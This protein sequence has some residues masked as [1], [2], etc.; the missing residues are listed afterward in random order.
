M[1]GNPGPGYDPSF[2]PSLPQQQAR[3]GSDWSPSQYWVQPPQIIPPP[4]PFEAWVPPPEQ[5]VF[6]ELPP[7]QTAQYTSRVNFLTTQVL[8]APPPVVGVNPPQQNSRPD[9]TLK[10]YQPTRDL[11]SAFATP[12]PPPPNNQLS[13]QHNARPDW[14]LR[15]YS[16]FQPMGAWFEGRTVA[17]IIPPPDFLV[18]GELPPDQTALLLSI[19]TNFS[20]G[21]VV[22]VPPP[23]KHVPDPQQNWRPY[24]DTAQQLAIVKVPQGVLAGIPVVPVG[25][26]FPGFTY[27]PPDM[28]ALR[29][30]LTAFSPP[31]AAGAQIPPTAPTYVEPPPWT[32]RDYQA[33]QDQFSALATPPTNTY[34]PGLRP[35]FPVEALIRDVL[36]PTTLQTVQNFIL[37]PPPPRVIPPA[38]PFVPWKDWTLREYQAYQDVFSA[39]AQGAPVAL[40]FRVMAVSAGIYAGNYYYPGDVFD[41]LLA[42]DYSDSTINYQIL[43]G[44]FATG[45]MLK[46]AP[47]TPLS[48][49]I[50]DDESPVF[51]VVDPKRRT[52]M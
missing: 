6:G 21:P 9:W 1:A 19:R 2:H 23:P 27:L 41:I 18:F 8:P 26:P 24:D 11:F 10:E 37:P 52:V 13:P 44:G 25:N 36:H 16:P 5:L 15:D 3:T 4:P 7:D 28:T 14:T 39:L 46:V 30:A 33:Y 20:R 34:P 35:Y 31:Q 47:S 22:V 48:Q 17:N 43:S 40:G 49:A 32:L 50:V 12:L 38:P 45:W 51:P 42:S 29:V